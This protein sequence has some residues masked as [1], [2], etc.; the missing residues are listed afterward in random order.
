MLCNYFLAAKSTIFSVKSNLENKKHKRR[1]PPSGPAERRALKSHPTRTRPTKPRLGHCLKGSHA[2]AAGSQSAPG[3]QRRVC[4][5]S[6]GAVA[7]DRGRRPLLHH[8]AAMHDHTSSQI[9]LAT[10]RSWVMKIIATFISACT[11]ASSSRICAGSTR[12]APRPPR[13]PPAR[14]DRTSA[15]GNADAL[16]L[17][18][19]KLVRE[20][21][22]GLRVQSD[23]IEQQP[24]RLG[25]RLSHRHAMRHRPDRQDLPMVWRGLSEAK[26][27]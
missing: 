4:G 3:S 8:H 25:A 6:R 24:Q 11:R 12:R 18:A 16:A 26:G 22:I 1:R 21:V 14:P 17:P 15:R 10:R 27:S 5:Y 19:G 7:E 20:P 23:E 2:A 9:W 13:R